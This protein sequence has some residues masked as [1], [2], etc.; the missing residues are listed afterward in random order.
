MKE[1]IENT[2]IAERDQA[3]AERK[4]KELEIDKKV[5]SEKEASANEE[6]KEA[7]PALLAAQEALKNVNQNSITEA[8]TNNKPTDLVL[9]TFQMGY[10]LWLDKGK[11]HSLD[12]D[13][14][15]IVK[16]DFL[17]A[18][19]LLDTLKNFPVEKLKQPQITKAERKLKE[20]EKVAGMNVAD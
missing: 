19:G 10:Y 5:I 6:Y 18:S 15:D 16:Q 20:I 4:E 17:N 14:F 12:N 2:E 9:F 8:K 1:I 3:A 11:G 7:Q 13:T